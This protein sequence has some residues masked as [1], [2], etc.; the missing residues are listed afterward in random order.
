MCLGLGGAVMMN[1][2]ATGISVRRRFAGRESSSFFMAS[3]AN[4]KGILF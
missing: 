3:G 2:S 1:P 4:F